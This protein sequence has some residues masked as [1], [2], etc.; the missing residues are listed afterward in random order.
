MPLIDVQNASFTY[1]GSARPAID[2]ASLSVAAGEYIAVV[3]LNGS[4]KSTLLRLLDGLLAP[5]SGRVLVD[6]IDASDHSRARDVRSRIALVFQSPIDQLVS[7][8]AEEDVAFGPENL[9][10]PREEIGRRVDEAL[11]AVGL[12]SERKRPCVF[13]SA[14][15][16]QRLALAGALAMRPGC[17]AFDEATSMLDPA[18]RRDVLDLMDT[19]VSAGTAVVHVTHDMD[20]AARASR[21]VV[22]DSGLVAFDGSPHEFF[23]DG[24]GS[25]LSRRLGLPRCAK[26]ASALGLEPRPREGAASLA[27]RILE[28]AGGLGLARAALSRA[29]DR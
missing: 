1:P 14:G 28:A 27:A 3:G 11:R 25:G 8:V 4:G 26:A 18:G 22:L 24:T 29:R 19:L 20:E 23:M 9:G 6:G 10:L 7:T 12:L 13:L 15:Q 21:I 16:Q 5:E 17:I 2:R